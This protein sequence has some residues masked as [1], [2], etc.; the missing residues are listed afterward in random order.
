MGKI[1]DIAIALD[2]DDEDHCELVMFLLKVAEASGETKF[3]DAYCACDTCTSQE[4]EMGQT[5]VIRRLGGDQLELVD[6]S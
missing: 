6:D 1:K 3:D 2:N 5:T 4:P